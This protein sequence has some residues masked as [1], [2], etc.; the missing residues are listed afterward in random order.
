[1][2]RYI[3][4]DSVLR[5]TGGVEAI[6]P[7]QSFEHDFSETGP[8]GEHGP[9]REA[10]MIA[11]GAIRVDDQSDA[12]VIATTEAPASPSAAVAVAA[13]ATNEAQKAE[14]E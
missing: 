11:S 10:A 3:A 7:G 6:Q 13:L 12:T 14:V 8:E 5:L 9:A 4:G 1:M 2:G